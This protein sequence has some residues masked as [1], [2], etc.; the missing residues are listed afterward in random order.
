[1]CNFSNFPINVWFLT[2]TSIFHL[3]FM[4]FMT[5]ILICGRHFWRHKRSLRFVE[6]LDH[7]HNVKFLVSKKITSMTDPTPIIG[8]YGGRCSH[9]K[10]SSKIKAGKPILGRKST[11]G[12]LRGGKTGKTT[13]KIDFWS[14][15]DCF[16]R[17]VALEWAQSTLTPRNRFAHVFLMNLK[18]KSTKKM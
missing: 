13:E 16:S 4:T 17:F 14:F 18:K 2:I 10:F 11:L 3:R 9:L 7:C 6:N 1:M 15:F 12:S 8:T 5:E